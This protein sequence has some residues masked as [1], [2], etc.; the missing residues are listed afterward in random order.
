[1]ANLRTN[2][3]LVQNIL[4]RS[5]E[6]PGTVSEFYSQ[7]VVY[8]NQVYQSLC[9]GGNELDPDVDETW[10]WLRKAT[11][12]IV[13]LQPAFTAGT[14]ALTTGDTT[15]TFSAPPTD[16]SGTPIGVQGWFLQPDAQQ[17]AVYQ[18]SSHTVGNA[19]AT[20]DSP[21]AGQAATSSQHKTY[22]LEYTLAA[23]CK[24][25][26]GPMRTQYDTPREIS[27]S[28]KVAMRR[29]YPIGRQ[30]PDIPRLF[31]PVSEANS[32]LTVQFSNYVTSLT[33]AE[34][35]YIAMP[36][37]LADDSGEPLVP[38]NTGTF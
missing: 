30:D 1:M 13:M 10:W 17:G 3:D 34:Y 7:A 25:V 2:S 4:A 29:H 26:I 15:A 14:V 5:S 8:Y 35:D 11:P 12:G 18:V 33:R 32:V 16:S 27:A 37:D 6:P 24:E 9:S 36:V 28:E 38:S 22:K 20:L 21:Y 19:V 23:D 31:A